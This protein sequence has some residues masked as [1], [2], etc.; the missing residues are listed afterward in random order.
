M[1]RKGQSTLE[2]S[3]VIAVVLAGLLA[4]QH[5][6]R[7]GVE[8]KLRSSTDNIGDQYEAGKTTAKVLTKVTTEGKTKETFGL[9]SDGAT[10][11]QGA[12]YYKVTTP[13]ETMSTSEAANGGVPEKITTTLAGETLFK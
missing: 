12:S 11:K 8:G 9:A 5:Y 10:F 6:M 4:M 7:R 1:S 13:T 2:Y 3:L